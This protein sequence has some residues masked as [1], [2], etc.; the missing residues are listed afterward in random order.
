M[1]MIMPS[2]YHP[3]N[4]HMIS[5]KETQITGKERTRDLRQLKGGFPLVDHFQKKN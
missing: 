5:Q 3:G 4:L 2:K 1:S